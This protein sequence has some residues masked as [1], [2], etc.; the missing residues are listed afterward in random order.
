MQFHWKHPGK[1]NGTAW[2]NKHGKHQ[3]SGP[4]DL[5]R[6]TTPGTKEHR[7][8]MRDLE[9]T[10]NYLEQLREAGVPVL[11]RPLHEI[12]GGWFWWTDKTTPENTAKLW[13][14]MFDYYVKQRKLN[15]LIW[16]YG[17]A[18]KTS[19]RGR[20]VEQIKLRKRYYPGAKYVHISSIAIY[21]NA[22]YGWKPYSEDSYMKAYR[23]MQEV[24]PGK[25]LALS[26]SGAIPNLEMMQAE[27][28]RWL[29]TLSWWAGGKQNPPAWIKKTYSHPLLV[30]RDEL[31]NFKK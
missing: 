5:A 20:D 28:P 30:T 9:K 24:S 29:Y 19:R 10:G 27:G 13:R 2:V 23:I 12:D 3:P 18:F 11:W 15:N 1:P 26:E 17:A 31:P 25:M 21:A 14:M 6:A 22:Y 7:Q 8:V 4:F 16:V